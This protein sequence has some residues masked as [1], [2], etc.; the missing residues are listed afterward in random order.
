MHIANPASTEQ[1][2]LRP[3]LRA[4][5]LA[6]LTLNKAF[7]DEGL[8][9][10]ELGKVYLNRDENLPD[11]PDMLCGVMCGPRSERWWQGTSEPMDFFDAK[12]IVEGLLSTNRHYCK[13][14]KSADA[15]LHPANQAAIIGRW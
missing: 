3:T 2:Y 13:F 9:L 7:I 4:G 5:L 15:N 1:E 12:G 11:E 8:R 14:E 10:F 6:A